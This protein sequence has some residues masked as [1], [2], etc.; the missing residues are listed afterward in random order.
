MLKKIQ[1][2]SEVF[3]NFLFENLAR[4]NLVVGQNNSGKTSLLKAIKSLNQFSERTIYLN[5]TSTKNPQWLSNWTTID[6]NEKKTRIIEFLRLIEPEL[7][8][9]Y[10]SSSQEEE[11]IKLKK[12]AVD[13]SLSL[14][15][16]GQGIKSL[17]VLA[18]SLLATKNGILLVDEIET[19]LHYKAQ[20]DIWRL[21]IETAKELNVQVFATTHSWDG[22]AAFG[23][24]LSQV[25]DKSVG[26]LFR[27]DSK[28]GQFRAVEY[29]AED[30]EL[31]VREN[32]EVR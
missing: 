2:E 7:E 4:V 9:I 30:L 18:V 16:M 28:Y 25:E 24:A 20:T 1:I 29:N 13:D 10:W 32:I 22:I 5:A 11:P 31:A 6:S 17:L 19:G 14:S 27:L 12:K 3:E 23:E 15:S 21:I 8:T 26:K